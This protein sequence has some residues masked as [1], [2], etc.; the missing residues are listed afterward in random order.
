MTVTRSA[1]HEHE[2]VVKSWNH[3]RENKC[4]EIF[5]Y[6]IK[7]RFLFF[8]SSLQRWHHFW[9]VSEVCS[10]TPGDAVSI[11][12]QTKFNTNIQ[13]GVDQRM[14]TENGWISRRMEGFNLLEFTGI[15]H[16]K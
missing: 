7:E 16:S 9:L 15:Y 2:N 10:L 13:Y 5:F 6:Y 14:E 3:Q 11:I 12:N 1:T 8:M 4:N